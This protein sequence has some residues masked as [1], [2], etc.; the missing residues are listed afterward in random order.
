MVA[1]ALRSFPPEL[2]ITIAGRSTPKL[3][4]LAQQLQAA[5]RLQVQS[6]V[7]GRVALARPDSSARPTD[8]VC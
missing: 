3:Q 5:D 2:R 7:W 8:G 1:E 6:C 4:A